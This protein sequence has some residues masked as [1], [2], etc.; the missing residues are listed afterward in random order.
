MTDSKVAR[1]LAKDLVQRYIPILDGIVHYG[2]SYEEKPFV[3][4]GETQRGTVLCVLTLKTDIRSAKRMETLMRNFPDG[5]RQLAQVLESLVGHVE[6]EEK[7]LD[8]AA[9]LNPHRWQVD[10]DGLVDISAWDSDEG[11]HGPECMDCGYHY[12]WHCHDECP[13]AAAKK[14]E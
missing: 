7:E 3:I 6:N 11:H 9:S 5:I 12:C 2:G 10:A 4:G 8:V 14:D 13:G 1:Q